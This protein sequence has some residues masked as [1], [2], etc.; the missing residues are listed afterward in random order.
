MRN[1]IRN[2]V[3]DMLKR[4]TLYKNGDFI[5]IFIEIYNKFLAYFS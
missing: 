2:S 3:Q 4:Y 1:Y 5:Y